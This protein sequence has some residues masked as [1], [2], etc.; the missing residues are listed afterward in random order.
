MRIRPESSGDIQALHDLTAAAFAPMSFSDGSEPR[1]LDRLRQDGDLTLSLIAE[2]PSGRLIGHIA[3]SPALVGTVSHGWYGLGPVSVAPDRQGQGIGRD[4]IEAGLDALRRLR[5]SGCVLIGDPRLYGRFGFLAG[6][7][8]YRDVDP[9]LVQHIVLDGSA[10]PNG[11]VHFAPAFE[12][13]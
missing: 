1:V 13:H 11:E 9:S 12:T 7:L 4:L 2:D 5:A 3:F 8:T 6:A 10:P